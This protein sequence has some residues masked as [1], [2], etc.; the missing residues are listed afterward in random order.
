MRAPHLEQ[1]AIWI[2]VI[3]VMELRADRALDIAELDLQHL[4]LEDMNRWHYMFGQK[5]GTFHVE[6]PLRAISEEF[7]LHRARGQ[8]PEF[9]FPADR[10]I[11][12]DIF[13]QSDVPIRTQVVQHDRIFG[14]RVG[15]F[16]LPLSELLSGTVHLGRSVPSHPRERLSGSHVPGFRAVQEQKRVRNDGS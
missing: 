13:F 16:Q 6:R 9:D 3:P 5:V 10:K 11:C 8:S 7:P 4:R 14:R 2:T 12:P 1:Q 15:A